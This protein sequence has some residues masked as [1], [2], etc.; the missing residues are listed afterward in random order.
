MSTG[1]FLYGDLYLL[2]LYVTTVACLGEILAA[3]AEDAAVQQRMPRT[4]CCIT[5]VL[6]RSPVT[7][8]SSLVQMPVCA[9]G[10]LSRHTLYGLP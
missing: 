4:T 7:P 3:T 2:V 8:L 9:C 1:M 6:L 10:V 5:Q